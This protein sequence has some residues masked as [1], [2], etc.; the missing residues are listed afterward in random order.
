MVEFDDLRRRHGFSVD[1]RRASFGVNRIR[2]ILI[3]FWTRTSFVGDKVF[4]VVFIEVVP[5]KG[6]SNEAMSFK[7]SEIDSNRPPSTLS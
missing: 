2:R 5:V 3:S 7:Y 4:F 6:L 1:I